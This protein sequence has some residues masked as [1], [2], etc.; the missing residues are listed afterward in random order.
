MANM[1]G[2]PGVG[3]SPY[4][5][6]VSAS[7]GTGMRSSVFGALRQL[8]QGSGAAVPGAVGA[9]PVVGGVGGG[10]VPPAN[11]DIG[12]VPSL[13]SLMASPML[14]SGGGADLATQL[15]MLSPEQQ[16]QVLMGLMGGSGGGR[17]GSELSSSDLERLIGRR[18]L[19]LLMQGGLEKLMGLK[20]SVSGGSGGI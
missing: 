2:N 8:G 16:A 18:V 3:S 12:Q 10:I 5:G 20:S 19:E 13:Q 17:S 9:A 1:V 7:G 11:V 14:G 6:A 15:S 4:H